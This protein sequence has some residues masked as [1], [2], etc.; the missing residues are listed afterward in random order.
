MVRDGPNYYGQRRFLIF[1][2]CVELRYIFGCSIIHGWR[3]GISI[4]HLIQANPFLKYLNQTFFQTFF[5]FNYWR[6]NTVSEYYQF[7]HYIYKSFIDDPDLWMTLTDQS[8][9]G[10]D[11]SLIVIWL[12][13]SHLISERLI[14]ETIFT[15][16]AHLLQ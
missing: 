10:N 1:N 5:T 7:N 13:N 4:S 15:K 2:L 11:I 3:T 16:P 8:V 14:D 12:V 9:I 6:Q